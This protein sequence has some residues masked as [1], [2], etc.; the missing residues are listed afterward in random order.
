MTNRYP[1]HQNTIINANNIQIIPPQNTPSPANPYPLN[2]NN[3]SLIQQQ[4]QQLIANTLLQ[5]QAKNQKIV[6]IANGSI[7]QPQPPP[8]QNPTYMEPNQL[9]NTIQVP[10]GNPHRIQPQAYYYQSHHSLHSYNGMHLQNMD[11][12]PDFRIMA[13]NYAIPQPLAQQIPVQAYYTNNGVNNYDYQSANASGNKA[14]FNNEVLNGIA[15]IL[16]NSSNFLPS[17]N[18]N[19]NG[20]GIAGGPND[21][22][23]LSSHHFLSQNGTIQLPPPQQH[24]NNYPT[25]ISTILPNQKLNNTLQQQQQQQQ[26]Q[27]QQIQK[28]QLQQ[29]LQKNNISQ[30]SGQQQQF[31]LFQ[32]Q[33]QQLQFQ[34]Q[35][36]QGLYG[37]ISASST[38]NYNYPSLQ[39]SNI[40]G[41]PNQAT[42]QIASQILTKE[43]FD[44]YLQSAHQ[45]YNS[46][47]YNAALNILLE[48]AQKNPTHLP[49]L[50]L[51]GCTYYS[52]GMYKAS[53]IYNNRILKID[54]RF[55]EAYSNLG[56]TYK[57]MAQ[58]CQNKNKVIDG[59][60]PNG[61][62]SGD[63]QEDSAKYLEYAEECYRTAIKIRPKYWDASI[64][65]AILVSSQG[66][67]KE[68]IEVYQTIESLMENDYPENARMD[69][70]KMD[71]N[72]PHGFINEIVPDMI[73]Q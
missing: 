61:K 26:Q 19:N 9:P 52:L 43:N 64:N 35:Q 2:I 67:W 63:D 71:P 69:H 65:L 21:T 73:E 56:T 18:G 51:L 20:I 15:R 41:L 16:D 54:S 34:Q 57:A 6:S 40:N 4:Q 1:S 28:Y 5:Q 22:N 48:L 44:Y 36:Q 50:L 31:Q 47:D 27:I 25:L 58:E 29:Q 59:N 24:L 53:I 12:P 60:H 45:K 46:Q 32:Q 68:A 39:V 38:T 10:N 11:Y 3:T 62:S 8:Q 30:Q 7:N 14:I 13:Y 33:Q 72:Q 66:R 49:T 23:N 42:S 37:N 70:L 55:S 17:D